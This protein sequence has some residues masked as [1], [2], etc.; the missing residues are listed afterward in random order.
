MFVACT[1]YAH[2]SHAVSSQIT[3]LMQITL[4][5]MAASDASQTAPVQITPIFI[6]CCFT[7]ISHFKF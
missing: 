5:A 6:L 1:F 4:N 2:V 7:Q 3:S